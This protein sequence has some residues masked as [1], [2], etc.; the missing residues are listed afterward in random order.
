MDISN[1]PTGFLF[2]REETQ[3]FLLLAIWVHRVKTFV[4]VKKLLTVVQNLFRSQGTQQ[5]PLRL[6]IIFNFQVADINFCT[7]N[8]WNQLFTDLE[9][10]DIRKYDGKAGIVVKQILV[11]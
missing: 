7:K 9:L 3:P 10:I 1:I 5:I 6:K 11:G 8:L 2:L 4:S